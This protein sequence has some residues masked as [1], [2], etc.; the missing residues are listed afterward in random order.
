ML[1]EYIDERERRMYMSEYQNWDK[2]LDRLEAG[3]SQYSWDELEELITDR[4]EDD[5]IDEQEFETL[6]RR[7]MD[8]DCEL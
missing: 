4:L 5:K 2:E 7:L 6:M 1:H 8:I 3:E